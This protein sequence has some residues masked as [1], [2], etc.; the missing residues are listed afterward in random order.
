MART[1]QEREAGAPERRRTPNP[2]IRRLGISVD[3]KGARLNDRSAPGKRS[4]HERARL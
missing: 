4:G 3:S 2:Q 1:A